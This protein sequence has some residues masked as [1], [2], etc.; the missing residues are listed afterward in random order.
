MIETDQPKTLYNLADVLSQ[1]FDD[2]HGEDHRRGRVK[3]RDPSQQSPICDPSLSP[4]QST[5]VRTEPSDSS[6]ERPPAVDSVKAQS[7][8]EPAVTKSPLNKVDT[9]LEAANLRELWEK[10]HDLAGDGRTALCLSGGGVRSAAFNLGVLQGLAR[11]KLLDRFHYLSTVSGGGYIGCWLTAW[12]YRSERGIEDL[13]IGLS[14]PDRVE[15]KTIPPR[16]PDAI[17]NLRRATNYLTPVKGLL[18][19]DTWATIIIVFRNLILNHLIIVPLIAALLLIL[20]LMGAAAHCDWFLADWEAWTKEAIEPGSMRLFDAQLLVWPLLFPGALVVLGWVVFSIARPS[21]DSR[22]AAPPIGHL[23]RSNAP[24]D[25]HPGQDW[26]PLLGISLVLAGGLFFALISADEFA[27]MPGTTSDAAR[28][29]SKTFFDS[30]PFWN[31]PCFS[32]FPLAGLVG[33]LL[34]FALA[35][36]VALIRR[37]RCKYQTGDAKKSW[38]LRFLGNVLEKPSSPVTVPTAGCR[39]VVFLALAAC[40]AGVAGGMVL[41]LGLEAAAQL[42]RS[43]P[44]ST[45]LILSIAPLWFVISYV[46]GDAVFLGLTVRRPRLQPGLEWSDPWGDEE[47]EWVA[48]TG[49]YLTVIALVIGILFLLALFGP[50]LIEFAKLFPI[51][52][53]LVAIGSALASIGLGASPLSSQFGTATVRSRRLP[54]PTILAIATPIFAGFLIIV[55]S[56][57]I[58]LLL[59]SNPLLDVLSQ[60]ESDLVIDPRTDH[61]KLLWLASGLALFS[62]LAAHFVNINRFSL[63]DLYRMRLTR[64]FLGASN[65]ERRPD[66]WTGFDEKDDVPMDRLWPC[67]SD[68]QKRL[69]PIINA[70]LNMAATKRLEWQERKAV[71]FIFTPRYCGSGATSELGFRKT[72]EYGCGIR[73]GWAMSV[74]GAAFSPNAG[75]ATMPGLALLMT[76]FNLRLGVWAGNPGKAGGYPSQK[77]DSPPS[78]VNG[79]RREKG[80]GGSS[81]HGNNLFWFLRKPVETYRLRGPHNALS[82]LINEAFARTDDSRNYVYLSDGGHFDNLGVYEMLRRRCRF[83]VV[84]DATHDPEYAY[85]DLGSVVRKAALDF[86]IRITFKHLDTAQRGGKAVHGAYSAFAIIEY[87]EERHDGQRQRGYLLYIKAFYQGAEE[88]ADVRAYALENPAFPH[89][90][91]LNQ[92]FGEAQFESY[93]VLGSY[94]VMELGRRAGFDGKNSPK[95]LACFFRGARKRLAQARR[96]LHGTNKARPP[97]F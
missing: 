42:P 53:A 2:L 8:Q 93:R 13:L 94:T 87:P 20:K 97:R 78:K 77:N 10:V 88:P 45:A 60:G 86:G 17:C 95:S 55:L 74:S 48:R 19:P 91:T 79:S 89:D 1:E 72:A 76:L 30:K 11:L 22:R 12:R 63:Y 6:G 21:W 49:G 35:V 39:A 29:C 90:T 58:D 16:V 25:K 36:S 73:L 71:S 52:L 7:V 37:G 81:T 66:F 31:W 4:L 69:Y 50:E 43:E 92:F 65:S 41:G 44:T 3:A 70:T 84:S 28:Y 47:R 59:F 18:S 38:A 85:A 57:A 62:W 83:I 51:S 33:A 82:P 67:R 32:A 23:S 15:E 9:D 75:Y 40:F 27:Q 96:E 68:K 34:A 80:A 46:V 56:T 14:W 26:A 5:N 61:L 24:Q 54:V 64:E